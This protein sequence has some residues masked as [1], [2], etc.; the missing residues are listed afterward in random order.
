MRRAA[1]FL[2]LFLACLV[3]AQSAPKLDISPQQLPVGAVGQAYS[4]KLTALSRRGP[5][6][7]SVRGEL[8]P[9]LQMQRNAG[10]LS[11]TPSK[12]GTYKVTIIAT[13]VP[14]G[15]TAQREYVIDITGLLT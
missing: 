12:G 15:E 1:L 9:G 5:F 14:T 6:E 3:Q 11:G 8:P 4:A 10:V 2:S 13:D 7:W